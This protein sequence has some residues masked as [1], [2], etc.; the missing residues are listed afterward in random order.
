MHGFWQSALGN[1]RLHASWVK[2]TA[3]SLPLQSGGMSCLLAAALVKA[4]KGRQSSCCGASWGSPSPV[5]LGCANRLVAAC[6]VMMSA[7]QHRVIRF[8]VS[9]DCSGH[10]YARC[11]A[12]LDGLG[13]QALC[14]EPRACCRSR[15][16][17]HLGPCLEATHVVW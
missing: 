6:M 2:V 14:V 17:R 12:R 16:S 4:C 13:A 8:L 5:S 15:Q 10:D 11:S 9:S 3:V 1:L 7:D